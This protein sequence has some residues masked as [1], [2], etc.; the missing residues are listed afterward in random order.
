M[1]ALPPAGSKAGLTA[2]SKAGLT[3]PQLVSGAKDTL[4]RVYSQLPAPH[5]E[6]IELP[7]N[8]SNFIEL[9]ES[10]FHGSMEVNLLSTAAVRMLKVFKIRHASSC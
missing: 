2:G 3:L 9:P 10:E 7:H 8:N 1:A 5:T 6:D 4:S